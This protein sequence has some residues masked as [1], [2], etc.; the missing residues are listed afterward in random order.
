MNIPLGRYGDL[1]PPDVRQV[2]RVKPDLVQ[3]VKAM[4]HEWSLLAE[5]LNANDAT[6]RLMNA[7]GMPIRT[8][9]D[10]DLLYRTAAAKIVRPF[11][12]DFADADARVVEEIAN[13][14]GNDPR[15]GMF[16]TALLNGTWL[17]FLAGVF[18]MPEFGT[19]LANGKIIVA[20]A[21]SR[22]DSLGER[23]NGV[24][25]SYS[26][27]GDFARDALGGVQVCFAGRYG[28]FA[29]RAK[30][31]VQVAQG[32]CQIFGASAEGGVEIDLSGKNKDLFPFTSG[33]CFADLAKNRIDRRL[34]GEGADYSKAHII[35]R[36]SRGHSRQIKEERMRPLSR[37]ATETAKE[38]EARAHGIS[39]MENL[40]LPGG[41]ERVFAY[42]WSSYQKDI[43]GLAA[44]LKGYLLK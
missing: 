3:T 41:L 26:D 39:F 40:T 31:G 12:D 24:I 43:E 44:Q 5:E 29:M 1:E 6:Q 38:M 30:G 25:V 42:D 17:P 34:I 23:C 10:A 4:H 32:N 13:A 20:Y 15:D 27:V 22:F 19:N 16:L 21:G 7:I 36:T 8:N 14:F 37:E 9:Y 35:V 18:R 11:A 28:D 33:F 2:P